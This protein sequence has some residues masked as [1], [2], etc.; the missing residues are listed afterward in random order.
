MKIFLIISIIVIGLG[1]LSG[2]IV[3]FF[4]MRNK[5]AVNNKYGNE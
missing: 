4:S 3:L 1:Y 2:N 5:K